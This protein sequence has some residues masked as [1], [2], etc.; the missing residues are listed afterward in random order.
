MSRIRTIKPKTWD[1]VKFSRLSRDSRLLYIA[2]WNF[3]DDLG[4]IIGD[5]IWIKSKVFPYDNIQMQQFEKWILELVKLGFISPLS[6]RQEGFYYLPNLTRHQVINRPN[7]DDLNIPNVELERLLADHGSITD[8]SLINHG[9]IT[10]Q[11]VLER[12]GKERK[13]EEGSKPPAKK[14]FEPP[15]EQEVIDYFASK[16]YTA[17]LARRAFNSY[18]VAGWVDSHGNKVLNWKQKMI[19]V[20][21]KEGIKSPIL[22]EQKKSHLPAELQG[23]NEW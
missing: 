18:H 2:M 23:R 7:L 17:D 11:S 14:V 3:C 6:Y 10:D 4:V 22:P 13:G 1:D 9:T 5:H 21:M 8:Q 15:T 12:K 19:N 16:G 20:W